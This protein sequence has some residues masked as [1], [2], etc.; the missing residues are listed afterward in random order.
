MNPL[1]K[2]EIRLLRPSWFAV[3]L[4]E[5]L[6]P[7]LWPD[8]DASFA[9][10][11]LFIF[12]GMILLSVD[13][14]GRE[15]SL[16]TFQSLLAQP[17][18]RRQIWRT[19]ITLLLL[20]AVLI[21]TGY[22][23][24]CELR[25][26]HAVIHS[27][28][29]AHPAILQGDFYQ[30][31]WASAAAMLVALAGGLWTALLFRQ[32]A[33]AFWI[34]F[35]APA[36]LVMLIVFVLSQFGADSD[37]VVETVL[38]VAAGL[39]I[40]SGFW[41]AH[42]L[43]HRAQ[44][45]A[46]TGGVISFSTWRYFEAGS[47]PSVS[48]RR[49]KPF[50]ALLKKE[51]QLHSI[52]LFCAG[53]LLALHVGIFVLRA[54]Y[55]NQHK[56]S[57]ASVLSEMFWVFWLIMPL[58]IGCMAVAEERKL[59]VM[60]DQLCLPVSR[61]FQ[62]AVKWIPAVIFGTLLGGLMPLLLETAASHL[63]V[64]NDYFLPASHEGNLILPGLAGFEISLLAL[65]AALVW[66]GFWASTLAKNFLQALSIAVVI[67]VG[68]CLFANFLHA[69]QS[70]DNGQFTFSLEGMKLWGAF[71]PLLIGILTFIFF[72]PCLTYRNFSHLVE[73]GRLWRRNL[74][75]VLGALVFVFVSSTLIYNRAWEIF[76]PAEPPHGPAI[77]SSVNPPAL[78]SDYYQNLQVRLPD[79]RIW[80]DSF[81][82]PFD[83]H[84][85]P[86]YWQT[87]WR[88]LVPPLPIS[89]GPRQFMAGSNWI[90][91]TASRVQFWDY[92][93]V[94]QKLIAG[95]L[96]TVGVQADGSLWI[97]SEAKP[98]AWTGADMT[99]F[100]D[101]TNWQQVARLWHGVTLLQRDGTLWKWGTNRL[102]WHQWRTNWPT[103]RATRP[104]Q[105]GTNSDWQNID[106]VGNGELI[107]KRDGSVWSLNWEWKMEPETN[108]DSVVL[109]TLSGVG[110]EMAYVSEDGRLWASNL[111]FDQKTGT[112]VGIKKFLPV[113]QETNWVAVAMD[114]DRSRMVALKADGTLW[115]W[116]I[117]G[118]S[119]PASVAKIPPTRLG[120]HRDW[121]GLTGVWD[122]AVALAAD[123]SLWFWPNPET[124]TGALLKAPKQ[125]EFLGN[126]FGRSD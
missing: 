34:T 85:R 15:C 45:A 26:H 55:A 62:F 28:W 109:S 114:G 76:E 105:I 83:D 46:W 67:I 71:P 123:G 27:I 14:F 32:V 10:A 75:G 64:P 81:R 112:W 100:G 41:L 116:H 102:D 95:Y 118:K 84:S 20:S 97:S 54:F 101:G 117:A 33:A 59:G 17:V 122:G 24:S 92:G 79:G 5:I 77:F 104:E 80:F 52:S 115:S 74:L 125:P 42:R 93:G 58:I 7:W 107:K 124:Y 89:T 108:L 66:V 35:L 63:G 94:A 4:L 110:G 23:I 1:V 119:P 37:A 111:N 90:S 53:A 126:V 120:I 73:T 68:G 29:R 57:L 22:F 82:S 12:F 69:S 25:L 3:L 13:S 19:K 47:K 40:L 78:Q 36:G 56:N 8:T 88:A 48:V 31:M 50:S 49:R 72:I 121:L 16:G 9:G 91:A 87:L 43:F 39:Y 98:R 21:F 30:A 11:P 2:K 113:G 60:E 38:Y 51:F 106:Y 65:A 6:L 99:R 70:N 96:D 61:R 44:D 86:R 103:M 18:A